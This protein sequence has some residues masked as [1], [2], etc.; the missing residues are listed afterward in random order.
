MGC[1]GERIG[2]LGGD[3]RMWGGMVMGEWGTGVYGSEFE[4]LGMGG[5]EFGV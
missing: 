1:V 3:L 5:R 4:K 2:V